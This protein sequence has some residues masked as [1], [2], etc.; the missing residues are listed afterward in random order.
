[1]LT[2]K[3]ART[4][5]HYGWVIV[6]PD[7]L[8][9]VLVHLLRAASPLQCGMS[10]SVLMGRRVSPNLVQSFEEDHKTRMYFDVWSTT[11]EVRVRLVRSVYA[12]ASKG[13]SLKL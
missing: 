6:Y 13:E 12:V 8:Y 11:T 9:E 7:V 2:R 5:Y 3:E 1:M 4:L 10:T